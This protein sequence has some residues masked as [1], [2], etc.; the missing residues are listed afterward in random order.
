MVQCLT[1]P[2]IETPS[3]FTLG[4]GQ[5]IPGFEQAVDGM[6]AGDSKTVNI[7]TDQAYGPH[8]EEMVQEVG[9]DRFPKN[10]KPH[11]GQ[12]F[13]VSRDDSGTIIFT[14]INVAEDTGTLDGNHPLAG[15]DLTFDIQLVEILQ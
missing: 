7:P 9:H 12:Q 11:L 1:P 13:Q 6:K 10:A 3:N 8:L 4:S 15:K 2:R 5:V 14:V